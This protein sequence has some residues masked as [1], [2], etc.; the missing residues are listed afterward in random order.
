MRSLHSSSLK[1]LDLQ[2]SKFYPQRHKNDTF[3]TGSTL[4]LWALGFSEIGFT[5][6]STE[7]TSRQQHTLSQLLTG[8]PCPPLAL[9]PPPFASF[10]R[11]DL[12]RLTELVPRRH[13][14][15]AAISRKTVVRVG[16]IQT[17][18]PKAAVFRPTGSRLWRSRLCQPDPIR[19][20]IPTKSDVELISHC[21]KNR[22]RVKFVAQN[23]ELRDNVLLGH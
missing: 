18:T 19:R 15:I 16:I 9:R 22:H 4:S 8:R 7:Q 11:I 3:S 20:E 21:F 23:G 12:A 5:N 6:V 14:L 2:A 17:D 1:K 10:G 13:S